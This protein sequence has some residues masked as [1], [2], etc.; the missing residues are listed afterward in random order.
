MSEDKIIYNY[1]SAETFLKIIESKKLLLTSTKTMNDALEM[2]WFKGLFI[3]ILN[4]KLSEGVSKDIVDSIYTNVIINM[5]PRY[6]SC[7]SESGDMLSQWRAYADD[8]R[9]I[10]I[11]F[12]IDNMK[13]NR[14]FPA[15]LAMDNDERSVG[16]CKVI[17][18]REAQ[19]NFINN[20]IEEYISGKSLIE[21]ASSISQLSTIFKNPAF[22]EEREWRILHSPILCYN[23]T[24]NDSMIMG[25]ISE[26]KFRMTSFGI[27]PYFDWSFANHDPLPIKE[28]ILGPQHRSDPGDID[29][30]LNY[31][32]FKEVTLKVSSASYRS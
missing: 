20:M 16:L 26:C 23:G 12:S 21:S 17:Y 11:G 5:S 2:E 14:M 6:I 32:G 22:L 13:I 19:E 27:S 30:F 4:N 9:G 18:T 15:T 28:V 25:K 31:N 7:F 8:G 3:N 10:A 1:C 29:F 24:S